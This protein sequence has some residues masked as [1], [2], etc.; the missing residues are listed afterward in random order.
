MNISRLDNME[1]LLNT[2]IKDLQRP[3]SKK[4][5]YVFEPGSLN[6]SFS[7]LQ[8]LWRCPRE[9]YL[10]ELEAIPDGFSGNLH[11]AF[12]S[13][14][15]AGIQELFRS[16]SLEYACVFALAHWDYDAWDDPQGKIRN[17]SF[18]EVIQAIEHF[19]HTQLPNIGENWELATINGK[20]AI[21][22]M[23][24][25]R[26]NDEFN[27]QGHIDLILRNKLD[28]SL[29]AW[30]MKSSGQEQQEANWGNSE[31]TLGY[32]AV[33]NYSTGTKEL[34]ASRTIYLTYQVN[35]ADDPNANF[36]FQYFPFE[37]PATASIDF[38][39]QLLMDANTIKLYEEAGFWPKRGSNCVRFGRVCQYYG[40]CDTIATDRKISELSSASKTFDQIPLSEVDF[41][42][43]LE[44]T[45]G[46]ENE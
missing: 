6:L 42:F 12:G 24:F 14:F 29:C 8:A 23:F 36:G 11:T 9:F 32:H 1:A 37:L 10:K 40:M 4:L 17:K 31:Q 45:L 41:V 39:N 21:E 26:I 16:G 25:I 35:K 7:R 2:P 5:A 30:E 33:L 28:N 22:M 27:Y 46:I 43:S 20:P 18:G 19:Y 38:V 44:E 13:A 3:K 15:G 34:S